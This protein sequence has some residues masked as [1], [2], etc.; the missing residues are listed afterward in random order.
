MG[1]TFPLYSCEDVQ[2]DTVRVHIHAKIPDGPAA[3]MHFG[4][5][6]PGPGKVL[7]VEDDDQHRIQE[8]KAIGDGVKE[9]RNG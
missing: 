8:P 4:T 2:T 3:I 6:Y 7:H 1:K 5:F 9:N